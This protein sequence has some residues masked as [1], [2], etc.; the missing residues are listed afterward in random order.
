MKK[1]SNTT[2]RAKLRFRSNPNY[3]LITFENL[4]EN[5]QSKL[6]NLKQDPDFCAILFPKKTGLTMKA[7]NYDTARLFQQ[8]SKTGKLPD[9]LN[10]IDDITQN[11]PVIQ[12]VLDNVL[13]MGSSKGFVSGIDAYSIL[14][15]NM[16][17]SF[18]SD[19]HIK[20]SLSVIALK[21][22]Q[23]LCLSDPIE[24]SK[25]LYFYNRM[26]VSIA[27]KKELSTKEKVASYLGISV[28]GK[29]RTI[30]TDYW[31]FYENTRNQNWF[32]FYANDQSRGRN[33]HNRYKIYIS[34]HPKYLRE[35]FYDTIRIFS[36][37]NVSSFKVGNNIHGIL[38]PDKLVAYFSSFNDLKST[39]TELQEVLGRVPAH[40]VPFT[41]Y[42]DNQGLI[43]WGV[44][45]P[46]NIKLLPW[47]GLSWRRWI[48]NN[49]ASSIIQAS[50][51]NCPLEPWE[52]ALQRIKLEG[53]DPISWIPHTNI[54][55]DSIQ[56]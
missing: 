2:T 46:H 37:N 32:F 35:V 8:M 48:T 40:G 39:S 21:Y 44:D 4:A 52:F 50:N 28:G 42:L 54:W 24:L 12:L 5:E 18:K 22:G 55:T 1:R 41:A 36:K 10:E 38:R 33:S 6:A 34:P 20:N 19:N 9:Y 7:V 26:P 23:N 56:E 17:T 13:E 47:D 15:R 3:E 30:L 45:P 27:W 51:S 31:N 53:I 29:S 11:K 25:R 14:Y 43:S 16:D 49:L